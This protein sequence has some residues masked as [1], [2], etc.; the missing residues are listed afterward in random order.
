MLS[1]LTDALTASFTTLLLKSQHAAGLMVEAALL[2]PSGGLP[3]S[4]RQLHWTHTWGFAILGQDHVSFIFSN[5][6][7][8]VW[9][10]IGGLLVV[11]FYI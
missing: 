6:A 10:S 2:I 4:H 11:I 5:M 1:A 3:S 9:A 8:V 7:A